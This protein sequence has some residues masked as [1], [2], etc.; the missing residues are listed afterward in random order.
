M[1]C[2]C[3]N[4]FCYRCGIGWV[5]NHNCLQTVNTA[6][7]NPPLIQNNQRADRLNINPP[8]QNRV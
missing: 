7:N 8:I 3:G 2:K 5:E 4:Q 1:T 6:V